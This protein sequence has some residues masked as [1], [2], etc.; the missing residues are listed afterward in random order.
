VNRRDFFRKATGAA[1]GL[2]VVPFAIAFEP[3]PAREWRAQ[4]DGYREQVDLALVRAEQSIAQVNM[5]QQAIYNGKNAAVLAASAMAAI[6][7][8]ATAK[9]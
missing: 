8:G 4:F 6:H 1:A 2:A 5:T 9:G 7:F 3:A